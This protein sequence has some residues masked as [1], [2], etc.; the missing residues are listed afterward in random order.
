[1]ARDKEG[2]R[3]VQISAK[4]QRFYSDGKDVVIYAKNSAD[5]DGGTEVQEVDWIFREKRKSVTWKIK[6]LTSVWT[7][8]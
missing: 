4:T 8:T 3:G 5:L 6:K 2:V 1:M 7:E